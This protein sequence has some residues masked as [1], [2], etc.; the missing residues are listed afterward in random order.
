MFNVMMGI[1]IMVMDVLKI[2]KFKKT[3]NVKGDLLIHQINEE[4]LVNQKFK[5]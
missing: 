2:V 1:I 5:K 3:I 4:I